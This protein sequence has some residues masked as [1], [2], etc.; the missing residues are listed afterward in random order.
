[1]DRSS[2]TFRTLKNVAYNFLA[3]AWPFLFSVIIT[4]IIIAK[5]GIQQYGIYIFI[6]TVSSFISIITSGF[7]GSSTKY[8]SEY[9]GRNDRASLRKL[10]NT[11]NV[12]FLLIALVGTATIMAGLFIGN[13]L[14]IASSISFRSLLLFFSLVSASYFIQTS[15][16]LYQAI[17]VAMERFDISSKISIFTGT[18]GSLGNLALVLMGYG[19]GALFAWQL[20][21]AVIMVSI[22]IG[23][24]L[25]LVPESS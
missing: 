20:F 23:I 19:I 5:L 12:I 10:F 4:P 15:T 6:N 17:P 14:S 18:L 3:Y 2:L 25:R 21:T 7:S 8:I 24:S 22:S 13:A 1:M 16:T 11:M 9:N